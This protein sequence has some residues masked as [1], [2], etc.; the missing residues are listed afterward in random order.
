MTADQLR[1]FRQ[2]DPVDQGLMIAAFEGV[3]HRLIKAGRPGIGFG[4][5]LP[6]P[7]PQVVGADG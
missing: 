7:G 6:F 4:A 3:F 2:S 1:V 5:R